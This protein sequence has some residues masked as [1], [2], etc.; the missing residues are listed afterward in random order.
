MKR[1]K[2]ISVVGARPNFM[3][4]APIHREFLLHNREVEHLICH[5][6]QHYDYEMS[7]IFFEELGLP[8]PNFYLGVG[9][10]SHG[11]QTGKIMI[12][13]EKICYQAKPDLVIVVGDVNSTISATLT[14]TKLGIKTAHV[15]AGLR[16]FDRTMPEEINRIATDSICDYLFV[17]EES[18]VRNLLKEG[19]SPSKI[20]FV[21]NTMIDSLLFILP[22]VDGSDIITKLKLIDKEFAVMTLHRPSNVDEKVQLLLILEVIDYICKSLHLVLPLHPR[23]RKNIEQFGLL[24]KFLS[25]PNLIVTEPLGY[26]DFIKL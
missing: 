20:F 22:K 13:F 16:S 2:V 15:E 18:G 11:E 25:I 6:G 10:G 24:S 4:V 26:I 23:T 1:L 19:H 7:K 12:E 3:K 8:R 9:S 14:A 21:G 5:T 17:T